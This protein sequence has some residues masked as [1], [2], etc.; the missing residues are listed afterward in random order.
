MKKFLILFCLLAPAVAQAHDHIEVGENPGNPG[1][2]LLAGPAYQLALFVPPGEPLS[3]YL[4]DFPGGF[5]AC[6]LTFSTEVNAL[7][8]ATGSM[9]RVE[10]VSVSGPVGASLAFWEVGATAPTW[11]RPAGWAAAGN[12]RPSLAV[13]QDQTG[14]GHIHGRAFTTDAA[15]PFVVTFRAVDE[16]GVRS[17]SPDKAITFQAQ[18]PPPLAIRMGGGDAVLSFVGRVG[19]AYDLQTRT[20]LASGPWA[21]IHDWTDGLG[22]MRE[23]SDP[24]AGKTRAFYRIVEYR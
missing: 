11:S 13:Y 15:G 20:N 19:L 23:F 24:V 16:N 14:Y 12:D 21:T 2:L 6:E 17:P 22:A 18:A 5:F 8:P 3:G 7:E 9:A 4:P 10:L 1:Q